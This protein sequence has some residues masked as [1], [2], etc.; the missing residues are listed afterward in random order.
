MRVTDIDTGKEVVLFNS[1]ELKRDMSELAQ[2]R[3]Q[4]A[5]VEMAQ[6]KYR[7]LSLHVRRVCVECG[8]FKGDTI[9]RENEHSDLQIIDQESIR[10]AYDKRMQGRREEIIQKH[11]RLQR[12]REAGFQIE[13]ISY[14]GSPDWKQ[15]RERVLKRANFICEGCLEKRAT[16]VHHLN[17][18]S[19]YSE[20][21]FDLVGLCKE[22]HA[23]CHLDKSELSEEEMLS[24]DLPC[25]GCR[26]HGERV[27]GSW[28]EKFDVHTTIALTDGELCGPRAREL[29]PLK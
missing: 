3:C 27:E 12:R 4:H 13:Y 16:V 23:K 5:N 1:E 15:R 7:N 17:Y 20:M 29:E 9:K 14:L 10:A 2:Q 28:C 8:A 6:V 11:V 26:C 19:I 25:Y 21:L 22:C 24:D 18:K